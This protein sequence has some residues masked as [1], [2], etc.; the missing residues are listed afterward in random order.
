M[1]MHRRGVVA[2]AIIVAGCATA[3]PSPTMPVPASP[4]LPAVLPGET[5]LAFQTNTAAGY[6][7]HLIRPDGTGLHRWPAAVPGTHEHPDWSP[8]GD[9]ILLNT[10]TSDDTEDLWVG[11][12]DGS[13]AHVLLDCV[14]P[15]L[16]VDEA[17][18]S[19]DGRT[20]AFQRLV[21][22]ADGHLV[23]TLEL[24]DLASGGKSVVLTMPDQ[25]VV[26]APRWS[27]KADALAVELIHLPADSLDVD[28]DSGAVGVWT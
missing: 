17:A 25:E 13:D 6:G 22:E 12:V 9:R 15:C 16:W 24:L 23:S 7:V 20:I 19:P 14:D 2:V 27:P 5:W 28:P 21:V 8:T 26:L 10:V 18:W 11:N 3:V 1:G 4:T